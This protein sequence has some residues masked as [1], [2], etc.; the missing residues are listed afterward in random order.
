MV[1]EDSTVQG[2]KEMEGSVYLQI[3]KSEIETILNINQLK[4]ILHS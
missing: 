1:L 2:M 4:T 3:N